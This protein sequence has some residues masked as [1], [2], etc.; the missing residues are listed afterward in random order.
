MLPTGA[1]TNTELES[2]ATPDHVGVAGAVPAWGNWD[3]SIAS[4][5]FV[6]APV[7]SIL[8]R[9]RTAGSAT[10]LFAD[11]LALAGTASTVDIEGTPGTT[12][13]GSALTLVVFPRST[14]GA[15]T[16]QTAA[17]LIPA[18]A[19]MWDRRPPRTCTSC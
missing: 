3:T 2:G 1:V 8:F 5:V 6:T 16:P 12:V 11:M 7:G 13:A 17:F 19:F 14:A 18:G 10:N 4:S 9:V 15:R